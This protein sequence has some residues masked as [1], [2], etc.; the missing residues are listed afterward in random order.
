MIDVGAIGQEH[1]SNG[2]PLLVL[3]IGLERAFF[4]KNE[5]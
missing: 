2:V 4:A 3:S 5:S 1:I